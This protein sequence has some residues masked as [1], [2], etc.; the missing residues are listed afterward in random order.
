MALSI[1]LY[2]LR[3]RYESGTVLGRLGTYGV[4][5]FFILSGLSMA[6]AYDRYIHDL[7]TSGAFFVRRLFRIW[8]LLWLAIAVNVIS[9]YRHGRPLSAGEILL[10]MST[11]FGFISPGHYLTIGAWSIGNEMVYYALTPLLIA[12]FHYRKWLGN[13]I[14]LAAFFIGMLFAFRL[15]NPEVPI[16]GQWALYV[17]PL[18]NL[19]LYCLGLTIFYT[20]RDA[21][22]SNAWYIGSFACAAI[23]FVFYPASGDQININV[24]IARMAL[25]LASAVAVLVCWKCP[26]R[27]PEAIGNR[28]EQLGVATYGVYLLHPIVMES[29]QKRLQ[30]WGI[31]EWH[32]FAL[33]VV[34]ITIALALFT[35]RFYESPLIQLGKRVTQTRTGVAASAEIESAPRPVAAPDDARNS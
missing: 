29:T 17:N 25:S 28:F 8:P 10:N 24:G 21:R 20:L 12:A 33:L 15:L 4:S 31:Y 18:N 23:V 34:G 19:F 2:H 35:F 22:I 6:I 32:F 3:D 14:T 26:P 13:S 7:R 1:M 9:E 5:V 27:L 16:A 30:A 11:L